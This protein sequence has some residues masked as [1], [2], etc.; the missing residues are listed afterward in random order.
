MP[1]YR[2]FIVGN[3]LP[4][5]CVGAERIVSATGKSRIRRLPPSIMRLP[6]SGIH[7]RQVANNIGAKVAKI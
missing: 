7:D 6:Q 2:S 5:V 4:P 3:T 1:S